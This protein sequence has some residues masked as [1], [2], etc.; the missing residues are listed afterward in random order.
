M[1][2]VVVAPLVL[3]WA[4]ILM[5]AGGTS[6][7]VPGGDVSSRSPPAGESEA[8]PFEGA[9]GQE[10]SN[11]DTTC[12]VPIVGS[13][14]CAAFE[15]PSEASV[16][17]TLVSVKDSDGKEY[18]DEAITF[19]VYDL[20]RKINQSAFKLIAG[21]STTY[22]N[23]TGEKLIVQLHAKTPRLTSTRNIRFTYQMTE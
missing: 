12:T 3:A 19:Y 2:S 15:L 9:G 23:D 14:P 5:G 22:K 6:V 8:L 17:V 16:T 13:A 7:V 11:S 20:N 1:L 10:L 18:K 21:G 4:G